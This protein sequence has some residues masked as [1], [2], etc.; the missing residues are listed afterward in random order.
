MP[1]FPF[2]VILRIVLISAATLT[3]LYLLKLKLDLGM[4][5]FSDMDE[6]AYISWTKQFL[7]GKHPYTDFYFFT[8]PTYLLVLAPA[9]AYFTGIGVLVAS[10][11]TEWGIFIVLAFALFFL[12]RQIWKTWLA[13]FVLVFLAALP[14][15]TDKFLE[16]RPDTLMMLL[17]VVGIVFMIRGMG[18]RADGPSRTKSQVMMFFASGFFYGLSLCIMQ[19]VL[20]LMAFLGCVFLFWLAS[21]VGRWSWRNLFFTTSRTI[22][23]LVLGGLAP[24]LFCI[25]WMRMYADFSTLLYLNFTLPFETNI[26]LGRLYGINPTF[27][28][29]ASDVYYG[30]YDPFPLSWVVNETMWIGAILVSAVVFPMMLLRTRKNISD[31]GWMIISG[32]FL[33]LVLFFVYGSAPRHMQYLIPAGTFIPV[34]LA[35][36]LHAFW[37]RAKTAPAQV[38]FFLCCGLILIVALRVGETMFVPKKMRDFSNEANAITYLKENL[39]PKD[40]VFDLVGVAFEYPHPYF[41]CCV[42]FG[43]GSA[44]ATRMVFPPL[45]EALERTKTNYIY[46]GLAGRIETLTPYDRQWVEEHFE[47]IGDGQILKRKGMGK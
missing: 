25:G 26:P 23:P 2:L 17:V 33:T 41:A 28:F 42:P 10:R 47:L 21:I 22:L 18:A 35:G 14:I 15:P 24:I 19:K 40:Y 32:A 4:V 12:T 30:T 34:I 20:V 16:V 1:L 31:W 5:R 38:V 13:V 9:V 7:S 45:R 46:Q 27:T 3:F 29:W 8:P 6:F 37:V 44:Y 36:L 39:H 43:Q 11:I